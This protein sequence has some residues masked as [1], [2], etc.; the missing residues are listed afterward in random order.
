MQ[1]SVIKVMGGIL[2]RNSWS[3][4]SF[5]YFL[6]LKRSLLSYLSSLEALATKWTFDSSIQSEVLALEMHAYF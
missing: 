1:D 5:P 4:V 3:L 2:H 6:Y